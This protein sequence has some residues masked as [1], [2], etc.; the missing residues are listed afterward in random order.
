M[1]KLYLKNIKK[2]LGKFNKVIVTGPP[3]SGTTI[4]GL[5]LSNELNY[6]F[7]DESF[8]DGNNQNKFMFFLTLPKRKMVLQMTAFLKDLHTIS[9]F[10]LINKIAVVLVNRKIPDILESFKNSKNFNMGCAIEGGIFTSIDEEA[11]Q[12][13]LNHYKEYLHKS[14]N[15]SLP[16]VIYDH[17][18][19]NSCNINKKML[20]ELDYNELSTHK[21][22][23]KKEDRRKKFKHIKQV[24][25]DPYFLATKMGVLT[26]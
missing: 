6:K 7:I 16:E 18:Y 10:L 17:F 25:E 8:Y 3:R 11:Q 5:I 20:F 14:D 4:S 1:K 19:V 2:E 23:I 15:R 21:L 26:L 12:I 24:T 9:E 22:F 13:I